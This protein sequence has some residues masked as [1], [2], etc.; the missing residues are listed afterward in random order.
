MSTRF[1]PAFIAERFN[2]KPSIRYSRFLSTQEWKPFHGYFAELPT[3]ESALRVC[4]EGQA[5]DDFFDGSIAT[6][7]G[8]AGWVPLATIEG[9]AATFVAVKANDPE[10]PVAMWEPDTEQFTPWAE[11]LDLFL[12]SL[13]KTKR[14]AK[15]PALKAGDISAVHQAAND[16]EDILDRPT[17]AKKTKALE[18][19]VLKLEALTVPGPL[20]S[21]KR[22]VNTPW[23][24]VP[25][26]ALQMKGEC[27]KALGRYAEAAAV[28]E[29]SIIDG[30]ATVI[31][32]DEL[33]ELWLE[34][35]NAPEKVIALCRSLEG[36]NVRL[37]AGR[38]FNWGLALFVTGQLDEA[39]RIFNERLALIPDDDE[40]V[41]SI[42]DSVAST[43]RERRVKYVKGAHDR[44]T[45]YCKAKGLDPQPLIQKISA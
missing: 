26:R 5:F 35:L 22:L 23:A 8:E 33:C 36:S 17:S 6:F 14:A 7:G 42:F 13:G 21:E 37:L 43:G 44:I 24:T 2:L 9:E 19:I 34:H 40:P 38:R 20:M 12:A 28:F 25:T 4:F 1:E 10:C 45:E 16:A 31:S 32:N 41:A 39:A 27:Y 3:Y 30:V 15:V 18:K 29:S 11:T